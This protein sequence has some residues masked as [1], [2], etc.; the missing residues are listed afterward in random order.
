MV[1]D[2]WNARPKEVY[3]YFIIYYLFIQYGKGGRQCRR[4]HGQRGLI[5]KYGL[6]LC[7]RCF[8]EKAEEIGFKK[9]L[10]YL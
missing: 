4:C 9:V 3:K 7:R 2:T 6:D 8:R 5:R 10:K 1:Q